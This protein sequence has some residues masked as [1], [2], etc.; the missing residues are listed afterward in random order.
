MLS[1]NKEIIFQRWDF[2]R[3]NVVLFPM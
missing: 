2:N 1:N 3:L